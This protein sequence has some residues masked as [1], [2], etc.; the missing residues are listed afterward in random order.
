MSL[1]PAAAT[2]VFS[3]REI[4]RAAGVSPGAVQA[5]LDGGQVRVT[6]GY[7]PASQAVRCVRRLRKQLLS[8]ARHELFSPPPAGQRSPGAG[9]V[10]SGAIHAGMLAALVFLATLGMQSTGQMPRRLD[11]MRLVFLATPGPGG[12]GGGG[13]LKQ[14]KLPAKAEMKGTTLLKSPAP[15]PKPLS[16]RTPEPRGTRPQPPPP[17]AQ[18]LPRPVEPPPPALRPPLTPQVVAPVVTA[19][20]DVRDRAGLLTETPSEAESQGSGSGGGAGSG[21]GSGIG[22]GS[23][24]GIGAGSGGGTGG[25]PYRPG[26]GITAPDLLHEVKPTY[27]EEARRSGVEG[28]VVLEIV[29]RHDG[30]V[31][32]VKVVQGLRGGLDRRA[33]EA[34]RQWRFSPARRYGTPVD[35]VVEVAV[36][37][38][39]R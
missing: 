6:R 39:L 19:S 27:T 36:E 8:P 38:K 30:T 33:V 11:P 29:V 2:E 31:G 16:T 37:F 26:S 9:I 4:A 5:L 21:R 20:S 10:A 28:D 32:Q 15:P 1:P 24:A 17:I 22:E 12:G 23:G 3:L 14:P 13:G 25:G 18:P 7:L 34:V 35:V